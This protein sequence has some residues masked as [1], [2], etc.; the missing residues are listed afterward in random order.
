MLSFKA[1]FYHQIHVPLKVSDLIDA[2]QKMENCL[3]TFSHKILR[4]ESQVVI[5]KIG[6]EFKY[7]VDFR[8]KDKAWIPN[9][10]LGYD[11]DPFYQGF[12]GKGLKAEI[13]YLMNNHYWV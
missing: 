13:S 11:N 7:A 10:I 9:D 3:D 2:S 1:H 6:D 8:L 5:L 12:R 4:K